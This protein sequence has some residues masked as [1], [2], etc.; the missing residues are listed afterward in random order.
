MTSK[1]SENNSGQEDKDFGFPFVEVKPL[2]APLPKVEHEAKTMV[3]S[4]KAASEKEKDKPAVNKGLLKPVR[5]SEKRPKKQSPVLF[6][7]VLLIVIILSVMAYFLYYLPTS[8]GPAKGSQLT[9]ETS[10]PLPVEAEG[11]ASLED[12]GLIDEEPELIPEE[13]TITPLQ[14]TSTEV[15]SNTG[16]LHAV[17]EPGERPAYHIIVGSVPNESLA[18]QEA[19]KFLNQGKDIWMLFPQ[20]DTKNYRL[21]VGSYSTFGAASSAL[22]KAK[23]ELDDSIWILKY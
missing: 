22:D 3:V 12:E 18:R 2:G 1:Q 5:G 20:G 23:A 6:S 13:E 10:F 17:N 9:E 4:D 14:E 11:A 21:S 16:T 15:Q 7:I 8:E 19:E